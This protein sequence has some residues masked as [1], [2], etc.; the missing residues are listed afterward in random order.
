ME[1]KV[2]TYPSDITISPLRVVFQFVQLLERLVPAL[3]DHH[4]RVAIL[5][6]AVATNMGLESRAVKVLVR[7]SLVHDLGMFLSNPWWDDEPRE[8]HEDEVAI[9]Y[10]EGISALEELQE[11]LSQR[12]DIPR[13]AR[14]GYDLVRRLPPLEELAL[15]ILFHHH[16]YRLLKGLDL[17]EEERAA[18]AIMNACDRAAGAFLPKEDGPPSRKRILSMLTSLAASDELDPSVVSALH[19]L[20]EK[21]DHLWSS[22]AHPNWWQR[23][24]LSI[25]DEV[26]FLSLDELSHFMETLSQV[27]DAKSPFT[28]KHTLHVAQTAVFLGKEMGLTEREI[29]TLRL[30]AFMHDLGKIA[31]PN[32]ILHKTYSLTPEEWTLMRQHVYISYLLFKDFDKLNDIAFVAATHHERLDGSG[33]PWGVS[34]DQLTLLSLILQVAD[35]YAAMR[36]DRPYSKG[37]SHEKAIESLKKSASMGKISGAVVEALARSKALQGL[38][39]DLETTPPKTCCDVSPEQ[40]AFSES[41]YP[42]NARSSDSNP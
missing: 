9:D 39:F 10:W 14:T 1:E 6:W 38:S 8:D 4:M 29:K 33:Y 41:E 12:G 2:R 27:I 11:E 31:M 30:A 32:A 18:A 5:S 17:R 24:L 26:V 35:I 28:K 16:P 3:S 37:S 36:E 42:A 19:K 25:A 40:M 13:H 23:E 22:M 7:A 34:G 20:L 21:R 15:P